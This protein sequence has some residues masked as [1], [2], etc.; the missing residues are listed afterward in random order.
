MLKAL[1]KLCSHFSISFEACNFRANVYDRCYG[2]MNGMHAEGRAEVTCWPH[3]KGA[4]QPIAFVITLTKANRG[5]CDLTGIKLNSGSY[6]PKSHARFEEVLQ[7]ATWVHMAHSW[8]WKRVLVELI[9]HIWDLYIALGDDPN[10]YLTTFWESYFVEPWGN[11][12]VG[13]N[14]HVPCLIPSNQ[15]VE[16]FFANVVRLLGGRTY[17]RGSTTKV[18]HE[19]L[20]KIMNHQEANLPDKLCFEVCKC[21]F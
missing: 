9:G 21:T 3:I 13:E 17:L 15:M 4:K 16:A 14:E 12:T 11:W 7:H 6:I 8:G 19:M 20:P 1:K 10:G 5:M 2:F 18:F